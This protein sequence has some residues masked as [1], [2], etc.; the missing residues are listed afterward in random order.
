MKLYTNGKGAWAGTQADAKKA[1]LSK[2]PVEVPTDKPNLITFL[3][4]NKVM[5][6]VAEKVAEVE[7]VEAEAPKPELPR[8]K[9][10]WLDKMNNDMTGYEISIAI[11]EILG[12]A[13]LKDIK[14]FAAIVIERICE[15]E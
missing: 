4:E 12:D 8:W 9:Q 13:P 6:P 14:N 10:E 11:E 2:E 1:Q 15:G 7:P 5:P 3:N